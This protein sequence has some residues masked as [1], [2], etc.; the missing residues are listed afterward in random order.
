MNIK[1]NILYMV[2]YNLGGIWPKIVKLHGGEDND[3]VWVS[4]DDNDD[5]YETIDQHWEKNKYCISG[6][7]FF[8]QNLLSYL[9]E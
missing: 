3:G 5:I 8:K 2:K 1:Q 4:V 9:N 6:A 7:K